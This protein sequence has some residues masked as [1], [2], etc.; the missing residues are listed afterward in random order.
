MA[1]LPI[2]SALRRNRLGAVLIAVQIALTLA[3]LCNGAFIVRQRV[4]FIER[5]TGTDEA[6]IFTMNNEWIGPPGNLTAKAETDLAS[7][8]ALPGVIDAYATNGYPL[9]GF[10][11]AWPVRRQ[12]ELT[13]AAPLSA[14]YFADDHALHTL[15]LR[16][17]AGRNFESSEISRP[18]AGATPQPSALIV[19]RD[20]ARKL[21]PGSPAIG[22]YVYSQ[23]FKGGVPI[24]GVVA[25]LEVPWTRTKFNRDSLLMPVLPANRVVIYVVRARPRDVAAIMRAAQKALYA[26]DPL[27]ILSDVQS[28]PDARRAAYRDDR[29]FA[30]VLAIVCLLMIAVTAFGI[31]GLTSYWVA[32]RRRQIG[33]RR[34]LGATRPA[35]LRYFQTENFMISAT[36][37]AGG[38]ALGFAANLWMV[39][40]F[41][42]PRMPPGYLLAGFAAVLTLGQLAAFWPALKASTM[43]PAQAT[44]SV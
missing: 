39:E 3:V 12:A 27:R 22:R 43:P 33:I 2:L 17:I 21:F 25:K 16:L 1:M 14:F 20:L 34:A 32:Q 28:L 42:M 37:G 8:R 15:G 36:G 29:G 44:R 11:A 26:S 5:P 41:Q 38:I 31:V 30:V 13:H 19:T 7:L 23:G 40:S 6:E 10:G 35:I 24:V 4:K 18:P 9:S